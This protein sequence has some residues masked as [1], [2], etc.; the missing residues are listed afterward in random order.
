MRNHKSKMLDV[1][2]LTWSAYV[3]CGPHNCIYCW[4]RPLCI[5]FYGNFKPRLIEERLNSRFKNQIV[6]TSFM[7]D[8]FNEDVPDQWI[9]RVFEAIRKSPTSQ[10]VLMTKNPSRY[11][12]LIEHIPENVLL[13][14][15][16]E[17][18]RPILRYSQ[19]PPTEK[20]FESM[21]ILKSLDPKLSEKFIL[22]IE[23]IMI[24]TIDILISW[25]QQLKPFITYV[26]Y[27]NHN[28]K[29]PEPTIEETIDL[30]AGMSPY[31]NVRPKTI[32]PAWDQEGGLVCIDEGIVHK[33]LDRKKLEED[34]INIREKI[35]K[36][37]RLII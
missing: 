28:Y 25:V 5:R 17:T 30:M 10:F 20:R 11:I 24:N 19:A 14:T 18:N 1:V 29:L 36:Q 22:I 26:G 9:L 32:R 37:T 23:P 6:A 21:M 27:D 13:G 15:T 7:G 34:I 4:A 3:G 2:N 16:I 33:F 8:L 12:R 35:I 31:T